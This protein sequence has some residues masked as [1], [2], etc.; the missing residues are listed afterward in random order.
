MRYELPTFDRPRPEETVS[1]MYRIPNGI[2][3]AFNAALDR[4]GMSAQGL[5]D[6]MV[7]HCLADAGLLP[8]KSVEE[9]KYSRAVCR[10]S[11]ALES[12]CETCERCEFYR[13]QEAS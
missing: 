3:E 9:P 5:V 12:N 7:Q 11:K 8:K 1:V 4:S 13:K 6:S 10:G 2:K